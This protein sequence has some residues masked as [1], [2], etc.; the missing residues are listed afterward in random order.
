[1]SKKREVKSTVSTGEGLVD[2]KI[3]IDLTPEDL[4]EHLA[5]CAAGDLAGMQAFEEGTPILTKDLKKML[6]KRS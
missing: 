5:K 1:M 2:V 6:I 4:V 3:I